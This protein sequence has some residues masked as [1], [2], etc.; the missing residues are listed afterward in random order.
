MSTT[1]T[2]NQ[3][4]KA[5]GGEV[6]SRIT[7]RRPTVGDMLGVTDDQSLS[8]ARREFNLL[9]KLSRLNPEDLEKIDFSDY[10][11]LTETLADFFNL[12]GE[13]PEE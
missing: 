10:Q 6:I 8:D 13:S 1:I 9:V 12:S 5:H 2:L 3:P 7:L 11:K 4:L